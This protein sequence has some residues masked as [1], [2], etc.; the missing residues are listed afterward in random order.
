MAGNYEMLYE[1]QG[2]TIYVL[3]LLHTKDNG[4]SGW[5]AKVGA[6]VDHARQ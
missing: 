1:V 4:D 3:R 5:L 6:L 2:E